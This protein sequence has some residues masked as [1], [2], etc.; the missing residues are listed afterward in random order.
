[1][2]TPPT[3]LTTDEAVL[4]VV[5]DVVKQT[6]PAVPAEKITL[7]ATMD[8]LGLDSLATMEMV[9]VIEQRLSIRFPDSELAKL[10]SLQQLIAL[11]RKSLPR[12]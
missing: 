10:G 11:I 12:A 6:A 5:R 3:S 2:T 8:D 4:E 1:V 9:G 7:G